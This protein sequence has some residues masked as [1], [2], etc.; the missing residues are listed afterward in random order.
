MPNQGFFL[1]IDMKNFAQN[2]FSRNSSFFDQSNNTFEMEYL[3][4]IR[5]D[6]ESKTDLKFIFKADDQYYYKN[7]RMF[8]L[9]QQYGDISSI[10]KN[11]EFEI[12]D[13]LQDEFMKHSHHYANLIDLIAELDTLMSFSL[14]A[15][16]FNY[17]KPELHLNTDDLE[18]GSFLFA[19]DV[20]H[21]LAEIFIDGS[22][23]VPNN[24][25]SGD[26]SKFDQ[27]VDSNQF[28]KVKIITSPNG[29]L[30]IN[31]ISFINKLNK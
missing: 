28:N 31:S 27:S 14:I 6:F 22:R 11:L 21:P 7:P 26:C 20:R 30:N 10:I 8:S 3:D 4:K 1:A 16:E 12:M 17:I 15:N 24:I 29:I 13:Q 9:D 18:S 23:F 25:T 19:N 2:S 5:A